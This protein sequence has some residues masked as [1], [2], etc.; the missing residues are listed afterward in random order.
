MRYQLLL[1]WFL[2]AIGSAVALGQDSPKITAADYARAETFLSANTT[3]LVYNVLSRPVWLK[4]D[5]LLYRISDAEGSR[6]ILADPET[7]T[8]DS[9]FDHVRLARALS[10]VTGSTYNAFSLPFTQIEFSDDS[11]FISFQVRGRRYSC[12]LET[13]RCTAEQESPPIRDRNMMISPDGQLG[14]FIRENNLWIRNLETGKETRLTT[15]G[16]EDFGYAT[17]NAGWTKSSRPVLLWSPNSDKIATFQHDGRGVGELYLVS[18][19]VGHPE[20][21]TWKC[22]LP[23]DSLIFRMSRVVIHLNPPSVVRLQMSPDPHR[24]TLRDHVAGRDGKW[25]DVEWNPDGSQLAFVSSSRDH[26]EAKLRMADPGTGKVR[27]VLEEKVETFFESGNGKINWHTL[28]GS[29][30]VIWFSER[31]NW[32]HLYLY[33]LDSGR[34]KHQ[35]TRGDW[36][37]LQLLRIDE[38]NR[39]LYFTGAGKESGDPYFQYFYRVGMDGKNFKKLTPENANHSISLSPSGGNF[40]DTYST[41]VVP[42]VSVLRNNEGEKL[43][44]PEDADVWRL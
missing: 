32:G 22:P 13:Y 15:D 12:D 37:V 8:R 26:K 38:K 43:V 42:P 7:G 35:I 27:D 30:E 2:V 6:F 16:I 10:S 4:N 23:G 33:D 31:D 9:A 17:N 44:E 11:R 28:T 34:L 1:L 5:R 14:A 19:K 41:P 36:N 24:S 25:L 40:V 18:T 39:I 20:L 3:P 21:Q 29:N